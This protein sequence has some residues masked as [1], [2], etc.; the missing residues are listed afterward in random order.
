MMGRFGSRKG[1]TIWV[2]QKISYLM[3]VQQQVGS[4]TIK[5]KKPNRFLSYKK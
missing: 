5:E 3:A 1:N 4:E 2:N